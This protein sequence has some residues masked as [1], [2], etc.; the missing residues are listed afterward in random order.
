MSKFL[1]LGSRNYANRRILH[2]LNKLGHR[3][4]IIDPSRLLPYITDT[5]NDRIYVMSAA[6]NEPKRIYKN[7][8]SGI[9]PR[10]GTDLQFYGKSVEHMNKNI[11]IP[12]T[13][14]AHGL[15]TA[16][17]KIKTVQVLSQ[18][19]IKTPRTFPVK[20]VYNLSWIVEKLGGFPVVAKT[21]TGSQGVGVFILTESLSA[22]TGL[23]AFTAQGNALLLQQFIETAKPKQT[24][25][26]FRAVVVNGE[27]VAAIRRNSVGED[28]RT[29][30]SLVEDCEGVELSAEM[31]QI[32]IKSAAACG[33][34][35]A[36]VDIA[37]DAATGEMYVYEVNGN[38]NFK[39]T[40]K[41]SKKNVALKI[42]EF[43]VSISSA[44]PS[45]QSDEQ[46]KMS[47][48][49]RQ[50]AG[51]GQ[52]RSFSTAKENE[53][54]ISPIGSTDGIPFLHFPET[55]ESDGE[56]EMSA[57]GTKNA[58]TLFGNVVSGMN[59]ATAFKSNGNAAD[60]FNANVNRTLNR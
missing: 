26:D 44:T 12:S 6:N 31:K 4:E 52:Y 17:D 59:A 18:N 28:F 34:A 2:E 33:L 11:G 37:T 57:F 8:I 51:L 9:I 55:D 50:I 7:T 42:A 45:V 15:L 25:H 10:I 48:N 27:V 49:L 14:T 32:A 22:S 13:A 35:C 19:G 24:K 47:A 60:R 38:F 39:S 58:K 29:N 40:E 16:Q 36:G 5:Q 46:A 56:L 23:D 30:A 21:I 3:A 1:I 54:D 20:K 53:L 41:Y 43:A